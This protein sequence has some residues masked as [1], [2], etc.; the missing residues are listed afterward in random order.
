MATKTRK[1]TTKGSRRGAGRNAGPRFSKGRRST[2]QAGGP[3]GLLNQITGRIGGASRGRGGAKG[4]RGGAKS[5]GL[6][7]QA[8]GFVR[9]FLSSGGRSGRRRR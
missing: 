3:K 9:G 5:G 7:S 6:A 4:G 8:S 1:Q 2:P